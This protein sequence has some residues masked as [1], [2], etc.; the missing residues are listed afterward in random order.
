MLSRADHQKISAAIEGIEK[1]TSGDIYC[2]VAHEAS[3][4]REVPLA[5]A[6]IV[7]FV[8]PVLVLGAGTK[9]FPLLKSL[10]GWSAIPARDLSHW[11]LVWVLLQALLFALVGLAASIPVVRRFLTPH[12]LKRH[13][14]GALARQ[15]FISTGLHLESHQPH[16]VI[17]VSLAERIVEVLADPAIHKLAGEAVWHQARDA[18]V[19]GMRTLDPSDGLVRAIEI[20]GATL[21]EHFPESRAM[22]HRDGLAE[23]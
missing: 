22:Q 18:I 21:I 10:E 5:W 11:M 17:F 7:A 6:S 2:I 20:A 9:I 12:F 14:V 4:Y 8:I 1:R 16:V 23:V 19:V 15:H 3:N 13:R